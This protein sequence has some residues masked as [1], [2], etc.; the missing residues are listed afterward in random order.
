M[1]H[2]TASSSPSSLGLPGI[3]W[4]LAFS[5]LLA[6]A[7][8]PSRAAEPPLKLN[9][10]DTVV[11][12]GATF[13]ER[14]QLFGHVE[15]TLLARLPD[16]QV[17]FRNLGW[18]GDEVTG[19]SRAVFGSVEDGFK[20]LK[21]DLA[22]ALPSVVLVQYG[23]VE[24]EAG[25]AGE[26]DFAQNLERLLTTIESMD[27]RI[28]LLSPLHRTRP[29]PVL[30]DP[31]DYNRNLDRYCDI[32]Q[33]A[34]A[35]RDA[36]YVD[37]RDLL[38]G[39][40]SSNG[41]VPTAAGYEQLA[42]ELVTRL[43]GPPI[44]WKVDI[45]GKDVSAE[46]AQVSEFRQHDDRLSFVSVDQQLVSSAAG[47]NGTLRVRGLAPGQYTLEAS[48][49]KV[50][51]YSASDL[52]KGVQ[53]PARGGS[54]Q[55]E[56]LRKLVMQKNA[57]FFHRHRPQNETYLFLFRKHEQGNNAVEVAQFDPLIAKAEAQIEN[58][59]RPRPQVY[60]LMRQR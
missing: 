24:A 43:V 17:R 32:L 31:A 9:A 44:A 33:T 45:E 23:A 8:A 6:S 47:D 22:L 58:V 60:K 29:R 30:P 28:V 39:V 49:R 3:S 11:W 25:P 56:Q 34:A 41:L 59:R 40:E 26:A 42:Q 27:A 10:G 52:A 53:L 7:P 51:E 55:A 2:Q 36:P 16:K 37:I 35:K 4:L 54:P 57:L 18:S 1:Q 48:G 13:L 46:G 38:A 12:L 19:I 21:N 50:G 20:R 5:L 14:M 15:T